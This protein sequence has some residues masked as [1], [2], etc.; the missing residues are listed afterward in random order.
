MPNYS[1]FVYQTISSKDAKMGTKVLIKRN[2]IKLV[3]TI[4]PGV[5][6]GTKVRLNGAMLL[7]D[8]L[9]GDIF[10]V[11]Q[12]RNSVRQVLVVLGILLALIF[13]IDAI[14]NYKVPS[15]TRIEKMTSTVNSGEN[16]EKNPSIPVNGKVVTLINNPDAK[17]PTYSQLI[18]FLKRDLTDQND[19][20]KIKYNCVDF[21]KDL[22]DHAESEGIKSAWVGIDFVGKEVGHAVNAFNTIDRGLV[23]I[24]VTAG[25]I[26]QAYLFSVIEEK[27]ESWDKIAYIEI[28]KDYGVIDIDESSG[29]TY[30]KFVVFEESCRRFVLEVEEFNADVEAYNAALTNHNYSS[31]VLNKWAE[32]LDSWQ[33]SISKISE[34]FDSCGYESQGIVEKIEI[35]W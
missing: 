28:G 15:K 14:V 7:T 9:S 17:D 31:G 10:V 33:N 25:I 29:P 23:F 3:A 12:I 32:D 26:E 19:Y 13:A 11:I 30:D 20:S 27:Y 16:G 22:H 21:A 8:N 1:T 2:G 34:N 4:P 18:Q 24:D 35:T 5:H 6:S